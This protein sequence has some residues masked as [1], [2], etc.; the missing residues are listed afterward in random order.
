MSRPA[1]VTPPAKFPTLAEFE[2]LEFDVEA[3]DHTAHVYVGWLLISSAPLTEAIHR[4]STTLQRLTRR[5][6]L[7]TKYN[8][9]ITWFFMILISERQSRTQAASW[10]EFAAA[11]TDLVNDSKT[12]L[13][14]HYSM[15]R[16]FSD[17]ARQ[18]FL[19]PDAVAND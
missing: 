18:Q 8:E 7:P 10:E 13:E 4:F 1:A 2:K 11:N 19:L 9:T 15:E 5:L 16:L 14:A 3:F 6:N 12:L 17:Q